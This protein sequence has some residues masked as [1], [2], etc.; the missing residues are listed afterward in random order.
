MTATTTT[1]ANPILPSEQEEMDDV[2]R[3]AE[4]GVLAAQLRL[5]AVKREVRLAEQA[6]DFELWCD[7]M[8]TAWLLARGR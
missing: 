1:P 7:H 3:C 5:D 4:T 2:V 8:R 6:D